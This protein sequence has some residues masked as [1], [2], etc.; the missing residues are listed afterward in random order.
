MRSEHGLKVKVYTPDEW[1][2]ALDGLTLESAGKVKK[3]AS[4]ADME[5]MIL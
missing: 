4:K 2:A 1:V 5:S 3:N